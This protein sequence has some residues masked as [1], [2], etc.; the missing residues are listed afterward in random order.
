M[1]TDNKFDDALLAHGVAGSSQES[2]G[3][4]TQ[5]EGHMITMSDTLKTLGAEMESL[6]NRQGESRQGDEGPPAKRAHEESVHETDADQSDDD[7]FM[8]YIQPTF[9]FVVSP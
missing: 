2:A 6:V 4:L 1:M 3:V 9:Q 8:D 7:D 5:L